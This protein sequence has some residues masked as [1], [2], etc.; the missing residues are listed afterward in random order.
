MMDLC[1]LEWE[2]FEEI[3]VGCSWPPMAEDY[4]E[5]TFNTLVY[6]CDNP[7]FCIDKEEAKRSQAVIDKIE[8]INSLLESKLKIKEEGKIKLIKKIK[9]YKAELLLKFFN[10]YPDMPCFNFQRSILCFLVLLRGSYRLRSSLP[11]DL[12]IAVCSC[13]LACSYLCV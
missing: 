6:V 12:A 13:A 8:F 5:G 1:T 4:D 10:R 7:A 2:F 11:V 3:D 9:R